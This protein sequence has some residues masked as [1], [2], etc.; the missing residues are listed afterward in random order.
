MSEGEP[1]ARCKWCG[2]RFRQKTPSGKPQVFCSEECSDNYFSAMKTLRCCYPNAAPEVHKTL[3]KAVGRLPKAETCRICGKELN[4]KSTCFATCR[5]TC[6]KRL[7]SRMAKHRGLKLETEPPKKP[8][9][10]TCKWCGRA[11]PKK[12]GV[13]V[14]FFCSK[15]CRKQ[16][17]A[18]QQSLR[19][20]FDLSQEA[21][22]ELALAIGQ[23]PEQ[24]TCRICGK[25]LKTFK[26]LA[27]CSP[28]CARKLLQSLGEKLGIEVEAPYEE[29]EDDDDI[30]VPTTHQCNGWTDVRYRHHPCPEHKR[31]TNYR[32][33]RCW[34]RTLKAQG[35][36]V[37]FRLHRKTEDDEA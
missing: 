16:Y 15:P 12:A 18:T 3:A 17:L 8:E 25:P 24:N 9:M 29:T 2:K 28:Y 32:C 22:R 23:L 30:L 31:T 36:T 33:E 21:Y 19:R 10:L 34:T 20:Q 26:R 5:L 7:I 11:T 37:P 14:S 35:H 13:S 1:R 6:T 27:T 4:R